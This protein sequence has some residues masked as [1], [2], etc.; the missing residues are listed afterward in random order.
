MTKNPVETKNIV[1]IN[2][3]IPQTADFE[4]YKQLFSFFQLLNIHHYFIK[5]NPASFKPFSDF[6]KKLQPRAYLYY[7]HTPILNNIILKDL[8]KSQQIFQPQL[9]CRK[10]YFKQHNSWGYPIFH[11]TDDKPEVYSYPANV[12]TISQKL[13]SPEDIVA[14]IL[15]RPDNESYNVKNLLQQMDKQQGLIKIKVK[16][17]FRY[18]LVVIRK[19]FLYLE[20]GLQYKINIHDDFLLKSQ[21]QISGDQIDTQIFDGAFLDADDFFSLN[22]FVTS[23]P[24]ITRNYS[25]I[26]GKKFK[27]DLA[28]FWHKY[29]NNSDVQNINISRMVNTYVDGILLPKLNYVHQNTRLKASIENPYFINNLATLKTTFQIDADHFIYNEAY[30]LKTI[31]NLKRILSYKNAHDEK[32]L[33]I[34]FGDIFNI[35][36]NFS[37]KKHCLD[38]LLSL[39]VNRVFFNYDTS[40][41]DNDFISHNILSDVQTQNIY[42]VWINYINRLSANIQ[43]GK[44]VAKILLLYPSMDFENSSFYETI[45][46][47]EKAPFEYDILDF[48]TFIN[49]EKCNTDGSKISLF[50]KTYHT[51]IL[52][53]VSKIPIKALKKIESFTEAGGTT[54]ALKCLPS[55]IE[56]QENQSK[57]KKLLHQIW[58]EESDLKSTSCKTNL[59]GGKGI[60]QE[61]PSQILPILEE[62]VKAKTPIYTNHENVK[63]YIRDTGNVYTVFVINTI[64]KPLENIILTTFTEGAVFQVSLDDG[65]LYPFKNVTFNQKSTTINLSLGPTESILLRI[66][67]DVSSQPLVKQQKENGIPTSE[68][69]E[70]DSEDWV[71]NCGDQNET[72]SLGDRSVHLPYDWHPVIYEKSITLEKGQLQNKSVLL[73]LGSLQ[74]WCTLYINNKKI[75]SRLVTPWDFEI[76]NF[77]LHGSN[78]LKIEIGHRLSNY[79]AANIDKKE[80]I[81]PVEKY[82]LFGPVN[83]KIEY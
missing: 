28:I 79:L 35:S 17:G 37:T 10:N 30:R 47:L 21:F 82:G 42:N 26:S 57:L 71:I 55:L 43:E 59:K 76:T 23:G 20:N 3:N 29:G 81:S 65:L 67:S 14:L 45:K 33:Q 49:D 72:G 68:L 66:N 25:R 18:E 40:I 53:S 15:L 22:G 54:I 8:Y 52:S 73:Q 32:Q 60:F 13:K 41:I 80:N 50:D 6:I 38:L 19:L 16:P 7:A 58:I 64:N 39:G 75:G 9:F 62:H 31:I 34:I 56:K 36:H 78:S 46:Q 24:E 69:I 4:N 44:Q 77:L 70:I 1:G 63:L 61:D 2:I 51:L 83:L 27:P 12:K 48:Q 5:L 74:D 11:F